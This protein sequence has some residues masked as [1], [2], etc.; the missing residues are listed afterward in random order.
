MLDTYV[1][2]T[3]A[4]LVALRQYE[5]PKFQLDPLSKCQHVK[6]WC[7]ALFAVGQRC[8]RGAQKVAGENR[9]FF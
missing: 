1:Y 7:E 8:K 3:T 4:I 9:N 6:M 2:I 5:K